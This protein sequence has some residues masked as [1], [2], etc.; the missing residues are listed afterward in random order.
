MI[1]FEGDFVR[2]HGQSNWLEVVGIV[3]DMHIQLSNG[4]YVEASERCIDDLLSAMEFADQREF[5]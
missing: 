4:S 1:I 5:V 3:D 2:L